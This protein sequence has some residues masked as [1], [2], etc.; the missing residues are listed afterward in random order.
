LREPALSD[1]TAVQ[2]Q[3]RRL[4][5]FCADRD[6][7]PRPFSV[8]VVPHRDVVRV[9]PVGEVD[10][11]TVGEVRARVEELLSAGFRRVALDLAEVTFLDAS[12][13]HLILE[14][15]ASARG[16][17][18]EFAV[19]E[20]AP[21]VQRV[22]EIAGVRDAVPFVDATAANQPHRDQPWR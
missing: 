8:D 16:D 9:A 14:L 15:A 19:I 1:L 5:G 20:G 3:R 6:A 7:F 10:L 12:G 4:D 22:F 18:W 21:D 17:G 13:L 11:A 2:A